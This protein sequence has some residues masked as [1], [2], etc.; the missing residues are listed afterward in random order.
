MVF[1]HRNITPTVVPL[2]LA[3]CCLLALLASVTAPTALAKG[4]GGAC[5]RWGNT[6]PEQL[7]V[8]EARKAVLCLL[9]AERSAH[10]LRRLDRNKKLQK[11]AQKHN[12][13]MLG[14]GCF[15]HEC[16]GEPTLE[17]RLED[18]YL[19]GDV[20][21]W[22]LGENVAWGLKDHG[23]PRAIVQT[24]MSSSGHRAN[25]LHGDFREVGIGFSAGSPSSNGAPGGIYTADFGLRVD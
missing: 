14:T 13:E 8:G 22:A 9:N 16:P 12:Q 18:I 4:G 21:R 23:T 11:A 5:E 17:D 15:A 2:L 19:V 7:R 20:V 10:G 1:R 6:P 24:W 3:G 25:I